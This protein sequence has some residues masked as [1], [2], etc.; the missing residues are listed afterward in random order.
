M[1]IEVEQLYFGAMAKFKIGSGGGIWPYVRGG[2]GL[3]TGSLNFNYTDEMKEAFM[4]ANGF[5]L[6]DES[7]DFKS[8]FGVNVGAGAELDFSHNNG[9]FAEFVYHI[10]S[11]ELD[12]DGESEASSFN[13]WAL[14]VGIHF[15]L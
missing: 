11:R 14:H 7:F 8:A 13:N 10:V 1:D 9:V 4:L 2:A 15:G 5:E 12:V 3:Y 6:E